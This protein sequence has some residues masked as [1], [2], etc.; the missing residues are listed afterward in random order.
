MGVRRS[1]GWL[2]RG[3][4]EG[5]S[6]PTSVPALPAPSHT[7]GPQIPARAGPEHRRVTDRQR[8][9]FFLCI[10]LQD[11]TSLSDAPHYPLPHDAQCHLC[12]GRQR[13]CQQSC[14]QVRR[15]QLTGTSGRGG[16]HPTWPLGSQEPHS[17]SPGPHP[18]RLKGVESSRRAGLQRA[19]RQVPS[20][21]LLPLRV[22]SGELNP[23]KSRPGPHMLSGQTQDSFPD[24]A[25]SSLLCSQTSPAGPHPPHLPC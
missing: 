20:H 1:G 7:E 21:K 22:E 13:E 19:Q 23:G 8:A 12:P 9:T 2:R 6:S 14:R 15:F 3:G 24:S 4:G 16:G 18:A 10:S 25:L 11:S 5:R 17:L